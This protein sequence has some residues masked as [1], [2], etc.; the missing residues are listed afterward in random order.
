MIFLHFSEIHFR[1]SGVEL[2]DDHLLILVRDWT[3]DAAR[4]ETA[5]ASEKAQW[6]EKVIA[7]R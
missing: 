1:A 3:L 7:Q 4:L 2:V 5:V 6:S